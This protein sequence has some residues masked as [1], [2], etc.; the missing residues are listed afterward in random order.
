MNAVANDDARSRELAAIHVAK[1]KLALDDDAYRDTLERVGGKRSA[2]DLGP[3]G[4]RAVLDHF[5]KLGAFPRSGP[6]GRRAGGPRRRYLGKLRAQWLSLYWLGVVNS[7][8]DAAIDAMAKRTAGIERVE[9][10]DARAANKVIEALKAMAAREAGVNWSE[11]DNPRICVMR[12]QWRRLGE[13][14]A[15]RIPKP[16]ALD[17]WLQWKVCPHKTCVEQLTDEQADAAIERLGRWIRKVKGGAD[18]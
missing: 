4:R 5:R 2:K 16:E 18:V 17:A 7:R 3:A 11:S 6:T 14:G 10:L 9:W 1:K 12:A 13:L 15:L 8:E